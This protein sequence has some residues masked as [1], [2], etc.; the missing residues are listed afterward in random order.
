MDVSSLFLLSFHL[1]LVMIAQ[2]QECSRPTLGNN[3]NLRD[4]D[5]LKD[6]FPDGSKANLACAVGHVQTGG[7]LSITCTAGA[8][9]PVTLECERRSCGAA[10]ELPNGFLDYSEGF[11]FG[12]KLYISCKTGYI[13]VGEPARICLASGK[14]SGHPPSCE[15]VT[16]DPPRDLA[17]GSFSPI[18]DI[19]KYEDFIQYMCLKD[20]VL[21]GSK[22]ASCS[23]D[24]QFKPDPP[25]CVKVNCVEIK[26]ENAEVLSGARPPYG[27]MAFVTFQCNSGYKMVGSPTVTC[28]INSHWS[29]KLPTCQRIESPTTAKPVD[30]GTPTAIPP[31]PDDKNGG[32]HLGMSLGIA[33]AVIIGLAIIIIVGC[34]Y[35]GSLAFINKKSK[36][37]DHRTP[38]GTTLLEMEREL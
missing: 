34:Y 30:K 4:D 7:S 25:V 8:W 1:G 13:L 29:P 26:I 23:A 21:N 9:S 36:N 27:H 33:F 15:V 2:A 6:I 32:N 5:I 10:E 11:Q 35:C 18:R 16:C 38:A 19:Y 14:W 37:G 17:E 20:Y 3:M 28:D 24:R 22:A 31:T 12:D